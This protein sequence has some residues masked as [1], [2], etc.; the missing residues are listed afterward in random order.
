M[1]I[2]TVTQ[3]TG[4]IVPD[5]RFSFCSTQ[6]SYLKT[7]ASLGYPE[8][9]M[10]ELEMNQNQLQKVFMGVRTIE[11][12]QR[13]NVVVFF[14]ERFYECVRNS[15]AELDFAMAQGINK[16]SRCVLYDYANAFPGVLEMVYRDELEDAIGDLVAQVFLTYVHEWK[17]KENEQKK[18]TRKKPGPKPKRDL[19]MVE[20]KPTDK[21]E[22]TNVASVTNTR[23][24]ENDDAGK[25][26]EDAQAQAL[27]LKEAAPVQDEVKPAPKKRRGRPRKVQE[28][29]EEVSAEPTPE[30][31][32]EEAEIDFGIPF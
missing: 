19:P 11:G 2:K 31:G 25:G 17:A 28:A 21:Q 6:K 13:L 7:L 26:N 27:E 18:K 1:D 22:E 20:D 30:E 15:K 24:D 9:R 5:V 16:M 32:Q 23:V 8:E 3:I 10:D 14:G 29:M 12:D 4:S